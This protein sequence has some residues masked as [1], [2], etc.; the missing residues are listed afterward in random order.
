[1]LAGIFMVDRNIFLNGD[2]MEAHLNN[3]GLT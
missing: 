1:M 3:K 2:D